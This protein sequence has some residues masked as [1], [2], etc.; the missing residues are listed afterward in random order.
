MLT[1]AQ[2]ALLQRIDA[3]E[4]IVPL[5]TLDGH[6][7]Y[8]WVREGVGYKGPAPAPTIR[9]LIRQGFLRWRYAKPGR[10]TSLLVTAAG[11]RAQKP[12]RVAGQGSRRDFRS[13]SEDGQVDPD[14]K[15]PQGLL[16]DP[17]IR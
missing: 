8:S 7:A 4:D 3:G 6:A 9:L 15:A 17:T 11:H 13:G 12:P 14:R 16:R 5:D 1:E 10:M 2:R